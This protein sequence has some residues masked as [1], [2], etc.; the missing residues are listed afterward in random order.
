MERNKIIS[1]VDK[2]TTTEGLV[3][4]IDCRE[5][6]VALYVDCPETIKWE[7]KMND[8]VFVGTKSMA[9]GNKLELT[10]FMELFDEEELE[11]KREEN[12][13]GWS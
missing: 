7:L 5:Q 13:Q 12:S 1:T 8:T 10:V 11:R 9:T 2:E 6:V 4:Q 3:Q